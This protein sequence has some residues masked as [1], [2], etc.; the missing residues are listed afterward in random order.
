MKSQ[1]L[2]CK[3]K[4]IIYCDYRNFGTDVTSL[5]AEVEAVDEQMCQQPINSVLAVADLR[6]TVTSQK[7]VELFKQSTTRTNDYIRKQ[8]VVG[9]SGIRKLLAQAVAR[10]SGQTLVLFDTTEAA[11]EWLV[12]EK[13]EGGIALKGRISNKPIARSTA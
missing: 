6:G 11:K 4:R 2:T 3:G 10:F 9:V 13:D 8:A 5:Q 12:S 1:W 7:V